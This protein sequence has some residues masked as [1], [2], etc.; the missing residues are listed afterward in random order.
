[1]SNNGARSVVVGRDVIGSIINTGDHNQFFIGQ[2]ERLQDAY[3]KPWEVFERTSRLPF[4]GREW[5]VAEI[6]AF[7]EKNDRG[8]FVLEAS[9][10]LG[11]TTFMA[12][13]VRQCSYIHHFC[14]LSPGIEGVNAGLRNLASQLA[15]AYDLRPEGVLPEAASRPDYL[16]DLLREAS[17]KCAGEQKIVVVVDALDESGMLGNRNVMGLPEGLP[18][19]V[20][21]LVSQRPGAVVLNVKDPT[22]TPRYY[23]RLAADSDENRADMRLF[24]EHTFRL[25]EVNRVLREGEP[26]YR[27]EQFVTTLMDKCDGVWIYL[28]Y[29]VQEIVQ[30]ERNALDLAELPNGMT[31]YYT[32]YWQGW[33]VKD[34][35][36][37]DEIYL[38]ILTTLAAAQE[39]LSC[40][41]LCSWSNAKIT[42]IKLRRLLEE[43]WR[44]FLVVNEQGQQTHYRFYHAT[45]RSFF[46]GEL[47][48]DKLS[49]LELQLLNE[50]VTE[51]RT[52]HSRFADHYLNAWGGLDG[53]LIGL[54]DESTRDSNDGYGVRYLAAHLEGS[55]RI[56]ELHQLLRFEWVWNEDIPYTRHGWRGWVDTLIGKQPTYQRTH[57]QNVWYTVQ[58]AVNQL[59]GYLSD[60]TRA[61]RLA[62]SRISGTAETSITGKTNPNEAARKYDHIGLLCRY[63]LVV[64][65][66]NNHAQNIRSGLLVELVKKKVWSYQ[67]G[68]AIARQAPIPS[69]QVEMLT[70]LVPYLSKH[71]QSTVV[72]EALD[73]ART[74][75]SQPTFDAVTKLAPYLSA[76]QFK[77]LLSDS[78]FESCISYYPTLARLVLYMPAE[79]LD[80]AVAK[81][82]SIRD[83]NSKTDALTQLAIRLAELREPAKAISAISSIDNPETRANAL[84]SLT[85]MLSS[86]S[87]QK[88]FFVAQSSEYPRDGVRKWVLATLA[89]LVAERGEPDQ[90]LLL[91]HSI[92]GEDERA[93]VLAKLVSY[94]SAK[95]Q[96][97]ILHEALPQ[98]FDKMSPYTI[99]IRYD[100]AEI[101]AN[102]APYLPSEQLG[103]LLQEVVQT[104]SPNYSHKQAAMLT[105]LAPYFSSEQLQTVLSMASSYSREGYYGYLVY[106]ELVETIA[107]S[108]ARH[109]SSEQVAEMI[110]HTNSI[111]DIPYSRI[112]ALVSLM[113]CLAKLGELEQA[114]SIT[115]SIPYHFIR[116]EILGSFVSHLSSKQIYEMLSLV[117]SIESENVKR[118]AVCHLA[119]RLAGLGELDKALSLLRSTDWWLRE[120]ALAVLAPY[121]SP[122]HLQEAL[123]AA[124]SRWR[125]P[126]S[127]ELSKEDYSSISFLL[128]RLAELGESQRAISAIRSIR[129]KDNQVEILAK[130][131]PYLSLEQLQE[132]LIIARS[133]GDTHHRERALIDLALSLGKL[134][135]SEKATSL[136]DSITIKEDRE[137]TLVKLI[138]YL[139]SK[140]LQEAI[141]LTLSLAANNFRT[142]AVF[143]LALRLAELG[144]AEKAL[145]LVHSVEDSMPR[146]TFIKLLAQLG[147]SDKA[148]SLAQSIYTG[149]DDRFE[150]VTLL[151][152][153]FPYMNSE[154]RQTIL[155]EVLS[156]F[157]GY[158]N[159]YPRWVR[160]AP[161]KLASYLAHNNQFDQV[162][163]LANATRDDFTRV[164]VW[165]KSGVHP[166]KDQ[167]QAALIEIRGFDE[168]TRAD[169]TPL[170]L[171]FLT[172]EEC[173]AVTH[174][175][176]SILPSLPGYYSSW[177]DILPMLVSYLTPKQLQEQISVARSFPVNIRVKA[178]A[179]LASYLPSEERREILEETI[180]LV[181]A[182]E[183][184]ADRA[185]ALAI[186]VPYLTDLD[187]D[188][189]YPLWCKLLSAL[190][191][192]TRSDLLADLATLSNSIAHLGGVSAIEETI[193]AIQDVSRWWP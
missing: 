86:E 188:A 154:G 148:L 153:L 18:V 115:H 146:D 42:E 187:P 174:E 87:L 159:I 23:Y 189:L 27:L 2:Y 35:E 65:S 93:F 20:Y 45:L 120:E 4:I 184:S 140:Q 150:R 97:D 75:E 50:V 135:E 30:G 95:Q 37:W 48:T 193:S 139:S 36:K 55:R 57:Y 109:F 44:P 185:K 66:I 131:A 17:E 111:N 10:G 81:A 183:K 100:K 51:T 71:E 171:P 172:V 22:T 186:L 101:L 82:R 124:L 39:S 117:H 163:S 91:A 88:V 149:S 123:S 40:Q 72:H 103:H 38:P 142:E 68:L 31:Q 182:I 162:F 118:I 62:E 152:D 63:A 28:Y 127:N 143:N 80:E 6:G 181:C 167:I 74:I 85:P 121:L 96:Q 157:S 14:E 112:N 164:M 191:T 175:I 134:G 21:F 165:A 25:P 43:R 54:R 64:A 180:S 132:S 5:L 104:I 114:L 76:R 92:E 108:F 190:S 166:S 29:V 56:D 126:L 58:E 130:L 70:A 176:L 46:H 16:Y 179:I 19:G 113:P 15:L 79:Q 24:L 158:F 128:V 177:V 32:R 116:V 47:E 77:E 61:W 156:I 160:D 110:S 94:V 161:V 106:M 141:P 53:N 26:K 178:L 41:Q 7:L 83:E 147:E 3:I 155:N 60:I 89:S 67:Q 173:Q 105:K 12:W 192:R 145:S 9:A 90:A 78:D 1:M 133:I 169:Y 98:T 168:Y 49:P 138:P 107:K 99:N 137:K 73:L 119:P 151:V 144:Q 69:Q 34:E 122:K 11:K 102:L 59:D 129:D 84:A 125:D 136:V 170:L 52:R 33:R 13:L 8:Y